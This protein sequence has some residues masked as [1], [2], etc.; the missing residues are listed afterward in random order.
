[1]NPNPE[2]YPLLVFVLSQLN[3]NDHP[4]L[5]PQV[6]NNLITK[7]PHLTNSTVISSLTQGVPV[8]ITQTRL[9]LGTRPDP[10]TVS[11]ARSKLAQ[12]HETATSSPEVDMYRAVVKLEEM[13]EDCERQFK[14]AEEMLDR[15]Y[16]SVSAELVDVNEDVVKILKEA[17]SGVVVET[18]DLADR[19]LKLLPEAFGRLRGLVSL[20][21]S[22]NLLE[23]NI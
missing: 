8:Q 22:R 10:D 1:M 15:V 16:D 3:P 14:E 12:F 4:P 17:E 20:N 19:Q 6:Y 5:P 7:Y 23:V 11:A 13:H 9:L 2:N 18:V 21:L